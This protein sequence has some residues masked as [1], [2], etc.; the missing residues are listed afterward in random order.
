MMRSPDLTPMASRDSSR[1]GGSERGPVAQRVARRLLGPPARLLWPMRLDGY[2]AV[3]S[4]G[5]AILCANHLSFIDSVVLMLTLERPVHFVGKAD[6]LDS[7]T[8]RRLFPAMGMIP[9]DR[10]NG[11]RAMVALDAAADVLARG[12]LLGVFPEGTRS[13]DGLLHKGYTGAARLAVATG[14]PILPVGITGTD[15]IQP[16]GARLPRPRKRCTVSIGSQIHATSA[17]TSGRVG[18]RIG[19]RA[20]TDHVMRE[21]GVLSGQTYVARYA[22]RSAP[23][24]KSPRPQVRWSPR[25]LVRA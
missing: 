4:M 7:W 13:R 9:I 10:N 14:C 6:Y 19:V 5:P 15:L 24:T 17:E 16:P 12:G 1:S 2:D 25:R 3:P 18:D 8:T 22:P 21:I 23:R 20:L 11:A